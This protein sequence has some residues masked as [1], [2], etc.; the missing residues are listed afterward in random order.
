MSGKGGGGPPKGKITINPNWKEDYDEAALTEAFDKMAIGDGADVSKMKT[1]QL[2]SDFD[3]GVDEEGDWDDDEFPE[4]LDEDDDEDED[5]NEDEDDEILDF[6]EGGGGGG[7]EDRIFQAKNAASKG[8]ITSANDNDN[9]DS[10]VEDND[11]PT[12]ADPEFEPRVFEISGSKVTLNCPGCGVEFQTK[13]EMDVGFLPPNKYEE[14]VSEMGRQKGTSSS[15][16]GGEAWT[17]ED[18]IEWL[19]HGGET[20]GLE[21]VDAELTSSSTPSATSALPTLPFKPPVCQRCHGLKNFGRAPAHLTSSDPSKSLL[22]PAT[23]SAIL[24]KALTPKVLRSNVVVI[25]VD[26]FDFTTKG[27]LETIDKIIGSNKANVILGVNKSDLFPRNTLTPLRAESWVR[28]ELRMG[29]ID[30]VRG[31]QGDVRLI[32]ALTGFGV[33]ALIGKVTGMMETFDLEGVYVIGGANVGKSTLLNKM[34][35]GKRGEGK[36][37]ESQL[38][39]T[40]LNLLKFPLKNGK[41]LYDTPGLLVPGSITT[42]LSTDELKLVC[43]KKRVEA[44][45][46]RVEPGGCVMLGGLARVDVHPDCKAFML[47]FFVGNEVVLHPTKTEKSGSVMERQVGK[48]LTPPIV[49]D[50]DDEKRRER[51]DMLGGTDEHIYTIHGKGWKEAAADLTIRGLGWFSVTGAGDAKIKVTVPKGTDVTMRED[52]LMP[53]DVWQNTGRF[54]GHKMVKKGKPQKG[55]RKPRPKKKGKN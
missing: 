9:L 34:I 21:K 54:T 42:L 28:R 5:D 50:D 8:Y 52:S 19:L 36:A 31:E 7:M 43:P 26:L 18:E 41:F 23:F 45:T 12:P 22:T 1:F 30:C 10:W 13:D 15:D 29:G 35:G 32:S 4:F 17:T 40:T 55:N 16:D 14:V 51:V 37:T 38:P 25:M 11:I 46:F 3:M 24:Q 2:P 20:T 39:G 49:E 44:K 33:Q 6:G 27:A 47:T 53:K 48:M